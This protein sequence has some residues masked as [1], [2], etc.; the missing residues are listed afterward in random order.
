M[1]APVSRWLRRILPFFVVRFA[2][3]LFW[4]AEIRGLERL[5]AAGPRVLIVANH[6]SSLDA[7]VLSALLPGRILFATHADIAQRWCLKPY[8]RI[9]DDCSLLAYP[10]DS[11]TH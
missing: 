6:V 1:V 7:V 4:R 10:V 11:H 8:W 5:A 3:R 9:G 2:L